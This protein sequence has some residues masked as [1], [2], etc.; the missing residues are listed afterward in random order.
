MGGIGNLT[1][2]TLGGLFVG[3]VAAMSDRFI[4]AKWTSVI[5]FS[6]LIL[7]LIFRPTGLLA[8][9]ASERA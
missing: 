6:L 5:V 7:V 4:E 1:G 8:E 3:I 9:Q 2:A